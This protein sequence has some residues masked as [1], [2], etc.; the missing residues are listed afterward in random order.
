MHRE[1]KVP[2]YSFVCYL[3]GM[4]PEDDVAINHLKGK[5]QVN[6]AKDGRLDLIFMC[7][8]NFLLFF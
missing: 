4:M 7:V 2:L 8:N 5:Q 6:K 1:E 3:K